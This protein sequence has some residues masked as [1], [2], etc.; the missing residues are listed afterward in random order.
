MNNI[1]DN[2]D[3]LA[4]Y[5]VIPL[6]LTRAPLPASPTF[7]SSHLSPQVCAFIHIHSNR[8]TNAKCITNLILF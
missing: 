3:P 8:L 6:S 1:G 4:F 5:S 2:T 7:L